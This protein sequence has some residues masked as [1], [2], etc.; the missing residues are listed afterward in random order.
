MLFCL[1]LIGYW[2]LSTSLNEKGISLSLVFS[3]F[4]Y[5]FSLNAS[6]S[7]DV[8]YSRHAVVKKHKIH[9][10]TRFITS[11]TTVRLKIFFRIF[12]N[13]EGLITYIEQD[14]VR[15]DSIICA[16]Q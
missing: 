8:F 12:V 5:E 1:G 13:Y 6:N 15:R 4:Y 10:T 11:F 2:N 9:I 3:F 14:N 7:G 16:L